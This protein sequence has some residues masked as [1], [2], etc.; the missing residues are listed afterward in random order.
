[1][2]DERDIGAIFWSIKTMKLEHVILGDAVTHK[3]IEQ[4]MEAEPGD[5]QRIGGLQLE[6]LCRY[7]HLVLAQSRQIF[8]WSL[9]AVALGLPF[10]LS[11]I[12]LEVM[13]TTYSYIPLL[14]GISIEMIAVILLF[15]YGRLAAQLRPLYYNLESLQRHI[16]AYNISETF[17]DPDRTKVRIAL[18]REISRSYS[19]RAYTPEEHQ[20]R[21]GRSLKPSE[22]S[23][24]TE[25]PQDTQVAQPQ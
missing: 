14:S 22:R 9:I 3:L 16:L 23:V 6:L 24:Q 10:F 2:T 4:V 15:Q 7:F 5:V 18:I 21:P 25:Q 20:R 19:D 13:N 1:M 12:I 11:S 17:A 8:S